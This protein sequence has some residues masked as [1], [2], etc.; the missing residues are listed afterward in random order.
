LG[1]M[2]DPC[3]SEPS[4][5]GPRTVKIQCAIS[6]SF[7]CS[8]LF[9]IDCYF[10]SSSLSVSLIVLGVN[11]TLSDVFFTSFYFV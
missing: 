4:F 3:R 2:R 10:F 7:R 11:V 5:A 9:I 1:R 8:L 6:L